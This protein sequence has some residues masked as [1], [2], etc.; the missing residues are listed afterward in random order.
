VF[1]DLEEL[2]VHGHHASHSSE[3]KHA[4][5]RVEN[6]RGR[7]TASGGQLAGRELVAG[8]AHGDTVTGNYVGGG[9][10]LEPKTYG[11]ARTSRRCTCY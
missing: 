1:R 7:R 2:L 11:D 6:R 8:H 9:R 3:N 10:V 4:A 5:V